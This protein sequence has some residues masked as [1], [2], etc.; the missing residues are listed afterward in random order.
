M[1]TI[2]RK[3]ADELGIDFD[4]LIDEF[5]EDS[6]IEHRRGSNFYKQSIIEINEEWYPEISREFDGYWET[7]TYVWNDNYGYDKSDIQELSR[8]ERKEK[9]VTT[10]EWVPVN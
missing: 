2:T 10:F 9:I 3:N 8:V 4:S 1:N 7:D 5:I 6:Y